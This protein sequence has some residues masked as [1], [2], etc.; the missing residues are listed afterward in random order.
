[1]TLSI[2]LAD[3]YPDGDMDSA[4]A[5]PN[6]SEHVRRAVGKT[7]PQPCDKISSLYLLNT[8]KAVFER[9]F[10]GCERPFVATRVAN[11][12]LILVVIDTMCTFTEYTM[13]TMAWEVPYNMSTLSCYKSRYGM[14]SRKS[15]SKCISSHEREDQ[16][17]LCGQ[18]SRLGGQCVVVVLLLVLVKIFGHLE[19]PFSMTMVVGH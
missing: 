15:L 7:K 4:G 19:R 11:S 18:G 13:S 12:N 14:L 8:E 9:G 6:A 1:M 5:K 16:I 17:E 3:Y 2:L 10:E